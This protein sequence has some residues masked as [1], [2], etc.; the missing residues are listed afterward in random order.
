M[1]S[2]LNHLFLPAA[3]L[4]GSEHLQE[5]GFFKNVD[6]PELGT[7]SVAAFPFRMSETPP[8]VGRSPLL[9]EH[10]ATVLADLGYDSEDALVLRE[11]GVA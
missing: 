2:G 3:S 9:G 7:I 4:P 5:R 11:R 1:L 6:H 10:T 8:R